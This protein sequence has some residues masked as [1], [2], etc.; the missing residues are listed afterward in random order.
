MTTAALKR[1]RLL[2]LDVDGVLTD[3]AI[4]YNDHGDELKSFNVKD[5]LGLRLLM[6][7]GIRVGIITGRDSEALRHRCR[8]L[9]IEDDLVF[10]GTRDKRAAFEKV[11]TH[12][13]LTADSVAYIGD[14]LPDLPLFQRVGLA[15]AVADAP[16]EVTAA[17]DLSTHAAGGHGA[18]R[19]VCEAILKAQGRWATIVDGF[20]Q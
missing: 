17:A 3:G 5:G 6:D 18:V 15:V 4:V 19:E 7:A 9:R 2:L 13:G 20:K 10:T 16:P 14:D 12:T 11:L 1:I 8:N